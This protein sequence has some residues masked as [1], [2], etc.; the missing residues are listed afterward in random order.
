MIETRDKYLEPFLDEAEE[1]IQRLNECL[2]TIEQ[3][4]SAVVD[5]VFRVAHTLKGMSATMGFQNMA[6]LTHKMEDVLEGAR[7][8]VLDI[9]SGEGTSTL[10][11]CLDTLNMLLGEIRE[12]NDDSGVGT[13]GIVEKLS[14]LMVMLP[15]EE[16]RK[17]SHEVSVPAGDN[18]A[19]LRMVEVKLQPDCMLKGARAFMVFEEVG[20]LGRVI[21]SVPHEKE[22]LE[23]AFQ[24]DVFYFVMETERDPDEI[25]MAV[26]N[27]GEVLS[28]NV[29]IAAEKTATVKDRESEAAL[30]KTDSGGA[31]TRHGH[32]NDHVTAGQTVRV[33]VHRLDKLMNLVGEL[34]IGRSRIEMLAREQGIKVFEGPI[35]QLGRISMEIQELV[36]KLRMLPVRFIFDRF[37]RIVRDISRE[38][39]KKVELQIV[40]QET[41]LDR[42]VIDEIGEPMV[43]LIRNSLDHGVETPAERV[44]RGKNETGLLRVSAFQ[45][46]SSVVIA[47]DDDGRGIDREAVRRKA[48]EKGLLTEEQAE[49]I[50]ERDLSQI[51]FTPGFSTSDSVTDLSGR[52]VG[53]DAVRNRVEALG[54]RI[55]VHSVPGEGTGVRIKL[56][57]T[58]AIVLALLVRIDGRSY[59]IPLESVEETIRIPV[60][61]VKNVNGSLAAQVR[62]TVLPL[63]DSRAFYGLSEK[64]RDGDHEVVVIRTGFRKTGFVVD[65]FIGQ[66]EIVI[67][68]FGD[69]GLPRLKWFSG[70]TILGD[71]SVA[72]IIDPSALD[73]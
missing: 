1:N 59:A 2:L 24:G 28:C 10:F 50:S 72:L 31:G 48:L 19:G 14:G 38:L 47:V 45:D 25:R 52:G 34:V 29:E 20:P 61:E 51:L 70:G 37:P 69:T 53:M 54:G 46:G 56:P 39:G 33:D 71:G 65:E 57:I 55:T 27:V 44:S 66:Q 68:S 49:N 58:L 9:N 6:H 30:P 15:R 60:N 13:E 22:L 18:G 41:E 62:G 67:K 3:G 23:G 26:M 63:V 5:E 7:K 64:H 4:D 16:D 35:L 21:Q 36:T 8:G 43:H 73:Q 11:E 12:K 32:A 17:T 40:G 42:S